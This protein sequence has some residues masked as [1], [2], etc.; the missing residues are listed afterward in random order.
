MQKPIALIR[1]ITQVLPLFRKLVVAIGIGLTLASLRLDIF[2]TV[3]GFGISYWSSW[4]TRLLFIALIAVS[5][6]LLFISVFRDEGD[7]LLASVCGIGAILLGF[8]LFIPVAVGFGH[9]G[10]LTAGPKLG[11]LGSAL[12][13]LG[14]LPLRALG[15]WRRSRARIGLPLY[16]TWLLAAM[17]P[18]LVIV[19]LG[20][21]TASKPISGTNSF[22]AT[23][24][25]PRYW[26]SVGQSGGHA[27][28]IF[29]LVLAVVAIFM[30]LGN[31]ILK[32]PVL[33]RWA[34]GASLL[35]VGLAVYY[36]ANLGFRSLR[37]LLAGGGL[38]LEGSVLAV[39]LALIAIA[40]E[41][42]TVDLR[43]LAIP[44][45]AALSGVGLALAGTWANVSGAQG[46]S[47]WAA[48]GTLAG[49]LFMLVV[50]GGLL[51][52]ASFVFRHRWLLPSVSILGWLLV[53][54]FGFYFAAAVPNDLKT[55]GPAVWLGMC[56][57]ALMGLSTV[58]LPSMAAW[59]RRSPSMTLRRFILWLAAGIGTGIVLSSL[60]LA[61]QVLSSGASGSH[62]YW[63]TAGDHSLGIVMLV[64]AVSTLAALVGVLITRLSVLSTW[65]QAASLALLGISLFIPVQDAFNHL[66]VL[67]SGAW[68]ALVGSLLASAGVVAMTLP[69]Q[70]L[71][72]AG[73]EEAEKAASPRARTPL[74]GKKPRVPETRRTK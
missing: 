42:G 35:L 23:G 65:A 1:T 18:I 48:D 34:L 9:L 51:L 19:S 8:F 13:V 14:A 40:A 44:R 58:S 73:P 11:V 59:K 4:T 2:S 41:R 38:A 54:Y 22:V 57:G 60:W 72:Q 20:R 24:P 63:N 64:F 70:R 31:A 28:G 36:P 25:A 17:A 15:S 56:G 6:V 61:T 29:M 39:V 55:L 49:F 68:L 21:D 30:A 12:I 10:D 62:S 67:R 45:L 37:S 47:F 33:G 69:E 32:A 71:G 46:S 27:L 66:G 74:K 53:G 26:D 7:R 43:T 3:A 16:V 5:V 52:A 50:L